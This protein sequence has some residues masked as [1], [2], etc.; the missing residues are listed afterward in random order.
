VRLGGIELGGCFCGRLMGSTRAGMDAAEHDFGSKRA[1]GA[2]PQAERCPHDAGERFH[3]RSLLCHVTQTAR[4]TPA[5]YADDSS[6][7]GAGRVSSGFTLGII[8]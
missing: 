7:T 8:L 3:L 1:L 6:G 5:P 2:S 4:P